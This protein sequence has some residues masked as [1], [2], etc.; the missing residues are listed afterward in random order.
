MR[1][2]V[3]IATALVAVTLSGCSWEERICG[4]GEYPV[5][6]VD[7][8]M[9]GQ[10]IKDGKE[11]PAGLEAYPDGQVPEVVGDKWDTYWDEKAVQFTKAQEEMSALA[12]LRSTDE[13]RGWK[14]TDVGEIGS[15]AAPADW[16]VERKGTTT[17]LTDGQ[18][19]VEVTLEP[20]AAGEIYD[21]AKA[22]RKEGTDTT[23]PIL[24]VDTPAEWPGGTGA[25][26]VRTNRDQDDGFVSRE[27]LLVVARDGSLVV[28]LGSITDS[29]DDIANT[30]PGQILRTLLLGGS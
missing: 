5:R 14:R 1:V 23:D 15:I 24:D 3:A 13:P 18:A 2:R 10:C 26:Y 30:M 21:R 17:L 27:A 12:S 29:D 19:T 20:G 28:V 11:P 7:G 8:G 4:D 9:G 16:E 22:I 6:P 25:R